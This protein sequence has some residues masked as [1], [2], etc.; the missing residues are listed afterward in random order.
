MFFTL[1]WSCLFEACTTELASVNRFRD[2][3]F[4]IVFFFFW[5]ELAAWVCPEKGESCVWNFLTNSRAPRCRFEIW[6]RRR[7]LCTTVGLIHEMFPFAW[8]HRFDDIS[9]ERL[10]YV[11]FLTAVVV[12]NHFKCT[13]VSVEEVLLAGG[14][15]AFVCL[16]DKK[17]LMQW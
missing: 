16:L 2:C 15:P 14:I 4:C 17:T 12:Q 7:P 3:V 5:W 10:V 8:T 9:A 6:S 13:W 1:W 11:Q